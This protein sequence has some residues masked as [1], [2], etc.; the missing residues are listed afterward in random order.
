[1]YAYLYVVRSPIPFSNMI[2]DTILNFII[3]LERFK[4]DYRVIQAR[5]WFLFAVSNDNCHWKIKKKVSL[6]LDY[7][8]FAA[9]T[10]HGRHLWPI[11]RRLASA[12]STVD[13]AVIETRFL[14][15]NP[16]D[17]LLQIR[18]PLSRHL[19]EKLRL[20]IRSTFLMNG[21]QRGI[22]CACQNRSRDLRFRGSRGRGSRYRLCQSSRIRR[23]LK[24]E[25]SVLL[26]STF[27]AVARTRCTPSS[28]KYVNFSNGNDGCP[29]DGLTY[30][31]VRSRRRSVY[32]LYVSRDCLK[33]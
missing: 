12:V 15:D 6:A 1:M 21:Y 28:N 20:V 10:R 26:R 14:S 2:F 24:D 30:K 32:I 19:A 22:S 7:N 33:F 23:S 18:K 27:S 3:K 4:F 5:R 16:T 9:Y 8:I 31:N 29:L 11:R 17:K 25:R 13:S